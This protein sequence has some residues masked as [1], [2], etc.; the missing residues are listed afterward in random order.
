[1]G[2]LLP[3]LTEAKFANQRDVVLNERRQNYE[4]RP[5][6]LAS[7][8]VMAALFPPDHPYHWPTIGRIGGPRMRRGSTTC[9]RSSSGTTTRPTRRSSWPATS[10][11][12]DARP[13]RGSTS[14]RS[15]PAS[16]SRRSAA[17]T[18]LAGVDAPA[19]SRIAS[20][21]RALYM[22]W[23]SPAM[24]AAGDAEL[25]LAAD[26]LANGKTS[27]L[28]R[29]LVYDA[30][31]RDRR[32]GASQNSREIGG[33][34]QIVATA[35]PGHGLGELEAAILDEVARL[36]RRAARPK[37]S[38][39]AGA[40]QA[41]SH[42]VYR[43]QTV[44]GFG[45]KSDQLNAYNV[46]LGDPGYFDRDLARYEEATA[47][48]AA[49]GGRAASRSGPARHAERRARRARRP[50][51]AGFHGCG[52]RVTVDRSRLPLRP[53][54]PPV[55]VPRHREV[56]AGER[57]AGLDGRARGSC[58]WCRSCCSSPAA[59]P[60]TPTVAKASRRSPPTCSTRAAATARPSRCTKAL[61]DLGTQLDADIG[62][63]ATTVRRR[64][65]RA[66]RRAAPSACWPT[67]SS[68]PR[69]READFA[70]RAARSA[71]IV[72]PSCSDVPG[73]V[74]ERAFARLLYGRHPYGH[75][76]IGTDR[77]PSRQ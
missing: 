45:G 75:S 74:A 32:V 70:A 51:R 8:A 65:A 60:T 31:G 21:C 4:N 58:R 77:R 12:R 39:S 50:G 29:R 62:P 64:R 3:A 11:G 53:V 33:F 7:M 72:S 10:T 67:W 34:F 19:C 68:G 69:M 27:R 16:P 37:P 35:A 36:S 55:R 17:T 2:F 47:D 23:Q 52:G 28:Y 26:L 48:V 13:R 54:D 44:G 59:R 63:D 25:D 43:L 24:F 41:E 18:A 76:P 46:F 6:G 15:P 22:A 61:A 38:S 56:P 20:S 57:P 30:S 1:M 14:E 49:R 40:S 42:F 9:R 5:Y 66:L 71:S 73:A